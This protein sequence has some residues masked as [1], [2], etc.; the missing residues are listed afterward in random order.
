TLG[1]N[2]ADRVN[3]T[4]ENGGRVV[5]V[6]TSA[7]RALETSAIRRGGSGDYRVAAGSEMTE[8]FIKPGYNFR[9]VRGVLTN[10]HMPGS[11]TLVLAAAFAGVARIKETYEDAKEAGYRFCSFGD[12][13]VIL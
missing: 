5:A 12:A 7:V 10:F 2:T 1:Q 11:T 6:G 13:M 3:K 8:L 9:V 4:L